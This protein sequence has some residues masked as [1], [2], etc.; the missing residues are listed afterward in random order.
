MKKEFLIT[1][2][3]NPYNPYTEWEE[4]YN[5]DEEMGYCTCGYLDRI[6]YT[7]PDMTDEE[8]EAEIDRGMNEIIKHNINGMYK[9]FYKE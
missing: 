1:T 6:T 4:W 2:V 8:F 3:D 7:T 9:R 5:W